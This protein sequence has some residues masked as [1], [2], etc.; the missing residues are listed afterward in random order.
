MR[1]I[2]KNHSRSNLRVLSIVS[3]SHSSQ[4]FTDSRLLFVF[5]F[6]QKH[7][8]ESCSEVQPDIKKQKLSVTPHPSALCRVTLSHTCDSLTCDCVI[9]E[10]AGQTDSVLW[11]ESSLQRL[12]RIQTAEHQWGWALRQ[13]IRSEVRTLQTRQVCW[14]HFCP[15]LL[16]AREHCVESHTVNTKL[17]DEAYWNEAKQV[18]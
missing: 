8:K 10:P 11:L 9:D 14:E 2:K 15:K 16:C 12:C 1:R 13:V 18:N 4:R 7:L 5:V 3:I 6:I 17:E